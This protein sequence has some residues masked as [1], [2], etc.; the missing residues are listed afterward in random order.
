MKTRKEILEEN[1]RRIIKSEIKVLT[2]SANMSQAMSDDPNI[3]QKVN[4]VISII[5]L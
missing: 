3:R 5:N 2:E 1:L 4:Q